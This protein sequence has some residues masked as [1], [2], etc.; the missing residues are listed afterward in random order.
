[1]LTPPDCVTVTAPPLAAAAAE[2]PI[3]TKPP[4][5]LPALPDPPPMDCARMPRAELP[6]VAMVPV[7]V[8]LLLPGVPAPAA[9]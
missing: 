1:M 9:A 3:A 6:P 7:W 2:P 5:S 8:T 4:S